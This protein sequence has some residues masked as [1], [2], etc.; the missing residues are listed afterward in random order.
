MVFDFISFS[1][2]QT[3][4]HKAQQ[5]SINAK[6]RMPNKYLVPLLSIFNVDNDYL[7]AQNKD[8]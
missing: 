4:C 2:L 6:Q 5:I 8:R 3:S 7:K 1:K